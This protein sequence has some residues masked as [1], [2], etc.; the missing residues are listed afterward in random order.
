MAPLKISNGGFAPPMS[1][2]MSCV[3]YPADPFDPVAVVTVM[4][5][6]LTVAMIAL[7]CAGS[8]LTFQLIGGSVCA[9]TALV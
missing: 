8:V 2:V 6:E 9:M 7:D 4:A 5:V 1:F 3:M